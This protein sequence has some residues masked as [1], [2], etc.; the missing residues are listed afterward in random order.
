MK[1]MRHKPG[2]LA[3]TEQMAHLVLDGPRSDHLDPKWYSFVI[4][5]GIRMHQFKKRYQLLN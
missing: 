3:E 5:L 4:S 2:D 1:V